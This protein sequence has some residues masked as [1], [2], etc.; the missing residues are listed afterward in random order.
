[1]ADDQKVTELAQAKKKSVAAT[2]SGE[3]SSANDQTDEVVPETAT[4]AVGVNGALSRF[5]IDADAQVK[6]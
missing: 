3:S 6:K 4:E 2:A 1:P 5:A